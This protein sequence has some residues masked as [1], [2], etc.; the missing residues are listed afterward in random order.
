MVGLSAKENQLIFEFVTNTLVQLLADG[1]L[2]V[3]GLNVPRLAEEELD[4]VFEELNKK[5]NTAGYHASEVQTEQFL[6]TNKAVQL[7]V[8][9]VTSENGVG[10]PK[11][12]AR[13]YKPEPDR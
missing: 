9:G 8:N 5:P 2:G 1:D 12:V 4:T 6:V 3:P 7:I 10:V 13:E 11:H